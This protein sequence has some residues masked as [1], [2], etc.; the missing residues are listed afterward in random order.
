MEKENSFKPSRAEQLL[1]DLSDAMRA[2]EAAE[3]AHASARDALL[4]AS[5]Q[6]TRARERYDAAL[7]AVQDAAKE[8]GE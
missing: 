3:A 2:Q 4:E 1:R 7:Q 5:R 6:V 8:G